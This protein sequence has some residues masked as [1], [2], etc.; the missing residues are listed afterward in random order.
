MYTLDRV[1]YKGMNKILSFIV[2]SFILL[3][4]AAPA[5]QGA[6]FSYD[7]YLVSKASENSGKAVIDSYSFIQMPKQ[8]I[9]LNVKV[10]KELKLSAFFVS[11]EQRNAEIEKSKSNNTIRVYIKDIVFKKS[12]K[13][14]FVKGV[15]FT[16]SYASSEF[17]FSIKI[18]PADHSN[19]VQACLISSIVFASDS[20]MATISGFVKSAILPA[21]ILNSNS[22]KF[23]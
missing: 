7:N 5:V 23:E 6:V 18:M 3:L 12:K 15:S 17:D 2:L 20:G 21:N 8:I 22:S 10:C 19:S 9:D 13:F 4:I 14:K 11:A 1:G 16:N